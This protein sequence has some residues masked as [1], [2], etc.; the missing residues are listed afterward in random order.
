MGNKVLHLSKLAQQRAKKDGKKEILFYR[1]HNLGQWLGLTWNDINTQI[2]AAAQSLLALNVEVQD[3]IITMAQNMPQLIMADYA[4]YSNRAISIPVFATAS[5][6]QLEYIVKDAEAKIIFVGGKVQ[7]DIA[8]EVQIREN[9]L[10][11][12][13]VI[14]HS[15]DIAG[16][17]DAMYY[18]DFLKLGAGD[19]E[20]EQEIVRLRKAATLKDTGIIMYTS[21]TTGEPKGVMLIH[22]AL[23]A[24]IENHQERLKFLDNKNE[25]TLCFLPLSH[26]FEKGWVNYCLHEGIKVYL[27]ENP[28]DIQQTLKEVRPTLMTNVPRFW[29]KIAAGVEEHIAKMKPVMKGFVAWSIDVG[30]T[31]NLDYKRKKKRA[32]LSLALRYRIA[33]NL[34]FN[35]LKKTVGLENGK[36]FPA[37]GAAM[38]KRLLVFFRSL[39][40]PIYIGYGLTETCASVSSFTEYGYKPGTAGRVMPGVQ[41]KIGE[42]DE[43]LV[44]GRSVTSGYYKKPEATKEAFVDGWFRTGDA[45]KLIDG[46]HLIMTDRIKDLFKTSNGKYIAPQ[47]IETKLG[48]DS[49]I[50]Q[51]AV[52]G[53]NRNYVTAIIAPNIAAIKSFAKEHSIAYNTVDELLKTAEIN[54]LF[55]ERIAEGCKDFASYETIKRFRLIK[56]GFTMEA[57]EMTSTLKLRRAV[58]HQNYKKLIHEMY[59]LPVGG[60]ISGMKG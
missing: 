36:M 29:E 20:K 35:R 55:E 27:N 24:M 46:D 34:V 31:Y 52:I 19:K 33:N 44:K 13:I 39:G 21:G 37:G 17:P 38:D 4:I 58:I 9:T 49:F 59:D 15:T 12:I 6:D 16:N 48:A 23:D 18:D 53:N 60:L 10:Q 56:E 47:L 50:E 30:R 8:K 3:R 22:D 57:G 2:N 32:P 54:T 28:H 41:V 42:N 45:G 7:Y 43:I 1:D 25:K 5:V 51:I 14:E 11:T 40:I 26:I